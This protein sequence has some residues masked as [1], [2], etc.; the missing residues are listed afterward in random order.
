M[1][2]RAHPEMTLEEYL[3][4]DNR[5]ICVLICGLE[6]PDPDPGLFID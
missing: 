5:L 3:Q 6:G 2:Q 1:Q 4:H